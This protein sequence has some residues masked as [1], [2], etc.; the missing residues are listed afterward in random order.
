MQ[1]HYYIMRC[2]KI[3]R[4]EAEIEFKS[5]PQNIK[6]NIFEEDHIVLDQ[7]QANWRVVI[8][9]D[10]IMEYEEY[11]E[12]LASPEAMD[13]EPELDLIAN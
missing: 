2:K 8:F 7:D 12:W 11:V 6:D 9:R 10:E 1:P 4:L 3:L 5:L 13:L